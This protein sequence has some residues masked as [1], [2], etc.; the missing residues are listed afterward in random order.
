MKHIIKIAPGRIDGATIQTVN[1]REIHEFLEVG[2]HFASWIVE[3]IDL[4][5]FTEGC[6]Y[7]VVY[8]LSNPNSGSSKARS[9]TTKEYHVTLDMAKQLSMVNRGPKG[10]EVRQYF[11]QC[12]KKLKAAPMA[13][14]TPEESALQLA[15]ALIE[16]DSLLQLERA[17]K[18]LAIEHSVQLSAEIGSWRLRL[19]C[20]HQ[21]SRASIS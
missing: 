9:Q 6:D 20:R 13:L 21:R 3:Q 4:W 15:R 10:Q 16:K 1:A 8:G 7:V 11:L 2:K 5:G 12:E 14:L 19:S 17:E 18:V